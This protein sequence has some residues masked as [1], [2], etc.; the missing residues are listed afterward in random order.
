MIWNAINELVT[1]PQETMDW[2]KA[3]ARLYNKHGKVMEWRTPTGFLVHHYYPEWKSRQVK[4]YIEGKEVKPRVREEQH[5]TVSKTEVT[6]G[7][8]ANYVHSFDAAHLAAVI[9]RLRDSGCKATWA[10]HDSIGVPPSAAA[11]LYRVVREEFIRLYDGSTPLNRLA[12][13][14]AHDLPWEDIPPV[15][16]M[17]DLDLNDILE[18][19]YF[20]S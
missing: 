17:G 7:I 11:T 6:N 1:G 10:I 20:F 18:A 12:K 19:R 2:L 14:A 3:V 16:D 5:G 15:P 9:L 8:S 13:Q 4:C